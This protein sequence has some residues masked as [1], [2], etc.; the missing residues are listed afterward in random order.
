MGYIH[1]SIGNSQ[2]GIAIYI[3]IYLYIERDIYDYSCHFFEIEI[4]SLG[5]SGRGS[6]WGVGSVARFGYNCILK[7]SILSNLSNFSLETY[8][9]LICYI[10]ILVHMS[11]MIITYHDFVN[12][13]NNA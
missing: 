4:C 2:W 10:V 11:P 1:V 9:Y 3:Y 6:L 12:M 8:M 7:F 13:I 5:G